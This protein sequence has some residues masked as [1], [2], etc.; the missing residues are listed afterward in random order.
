M[1]DLSTHTGVRSTAGSL[2]L[3]SAGSVVVPF[4]SDDGGVC[5]ASRIVASATA[6]CVSR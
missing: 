2:M 1:F 5:P 3:E 4:T 6:A